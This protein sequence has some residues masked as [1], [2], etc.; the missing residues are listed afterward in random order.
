MRLQRD[1]ALLAQTKKRSA[2]EPDGAAARSADIGGDGA[3]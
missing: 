3:L 1:K 2:R